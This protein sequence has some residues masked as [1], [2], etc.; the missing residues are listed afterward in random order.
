MQDATWRE[1]LTDLFKEADR[2]VSRMR[3]RGNRRVRGLLC[4]RAALCWHVASEQ[5]PDGAVTAVIKPLPPG[6]DDLVVFYQSASE[7]TQLTLMFDPL[8]VD[9]LLERLPPGAWQRAERI[10]VS[11]RMELR[12]VD[13]VDTLIGGAEVLEMSE[14]KTLMQ[15][16]DIEPSALLYRMKML[17]NRLSFEKQRSRLRHKIQ[18]LL[19]NHGFFD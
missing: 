12:V 13:P 6:I 9:T 17:M 15:H 16:A 7:T 4:D 2:L 11:E 3:H 14:L 10:E 19:T 8:H 1:A 18:P 5:L